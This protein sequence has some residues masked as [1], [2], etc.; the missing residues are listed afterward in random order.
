MRRKWGAVIT[1]PMVCQA[2]G[3][4]IPEE[5]VEFHPTR[6]WRADFLWRAQKVILE[7]EGGLFASGRALAA[8]GRPLG[9]RR[10]MEKANAAQLL[11]YRYFRV[12]PCD[13]ESGKVVELLKQIFVQ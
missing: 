8:H 5:E 13:I 7:K 12:E 2:H 10:D 3:L 11:G 6:K 4:P 9:I 1:L